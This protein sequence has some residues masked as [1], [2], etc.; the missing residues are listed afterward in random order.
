MSAYVAQE[1][2]EENQRETMTRPLA[3]VWR[4]SAGIVAVCCLAACGPA[5]DGDQG[6]RGPLTSAVSRE[7]LTTVIDSIAADALAGGPI[8]GLSIAVTKGGQPLVVK[9]D[10]KSVV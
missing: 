6:V 10:R 9:G 8:A 1:N 2:P 7:A 4:S 3:V 5:S